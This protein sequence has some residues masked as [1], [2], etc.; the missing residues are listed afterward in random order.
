MKFFGLDQ[1]AMYDQGVMDDQGTMDSQGA[2]DDRSRKDV[3]DADHRYVRLYCNTHKRR[4]R[5]VMEPS[6]T[7]YFLVFS[8]VIRYTHSA[9]LV[10]KK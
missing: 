6:A 10:K 9:G 4:S 2:L 5:Q 1:G 7:L 8:C 3:W